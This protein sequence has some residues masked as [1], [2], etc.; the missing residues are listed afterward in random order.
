MQLGDCPFQEGFVLHLLFHFFDGDRL[1]VAHVLVRAAIGDIE[2]KLCNPD[3]TYSGEKST[4]PN[5]NRYTV[6]EAGWLVTPGLHNDILAPAEDPVHDVGCS[7]SIK[8]PLGVVAVLGLSTA[9]VHISIQLMP[10]QSK[11]FEVHLVKGRVPLSWCSGVSESRLE[12]LRDLIV[13]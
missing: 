11:L 2:A 8:D 13:S 10:H 4:L 7:F 1:D 12:D 5:L 6:Q 9:Q 3:N